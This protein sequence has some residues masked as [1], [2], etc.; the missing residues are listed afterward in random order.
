MDTAV[1]AVAV[2]LTVAVV[3]LWSVRTFVA[4]IA[5]GRGDGQLIHRPRQVRRLDVLLWGLGLLWGASLAT[6][7][8]LGL[9]GL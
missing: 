4:E 3:A 1:A 5:Y 9:A 6:Y 8:G 2:V 7:L